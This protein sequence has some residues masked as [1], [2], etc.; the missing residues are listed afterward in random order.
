QGLSLGIKQ[1][2]AI[3][4][5]FLLSPNIIVLDEATSSIDTMTEQFIYEGFDKIMQ[6]KTAFIVAHRLSTI[7][8]A[9]LILVIK[10]GLLIEQ[11]KH[12][13][14][15]EKKGFYYSLVQAQNQ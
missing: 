5:V 6:G 11:G 15:L 8:N 7:I 2:L 1:L 4:R 13:E 12:Q 10:D 3:S 14:L 9:D